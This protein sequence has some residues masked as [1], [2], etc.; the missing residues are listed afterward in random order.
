MASNLSPR[1][2]S[3]RSSFSP[4]AHLTT[5]APFRVRAAARIRPVMRDDRRRAG[6]RVPVSRCLSAAGVRFLVILCPLGSWAFL[7][8][9]LPARVAKG[10]TP[11]GLSR[12]AR[13]RCDRVGCPLCP[14]DCGAR[15][16]WHRF[17]SRRMPLHNGRVPKPRNHDP[18]P[19]LDVTRRHRGFTVVHPSGLPLACD[20]RVERR[21]LGFSPRAS[22]PAVAGG[23]CR[24]GDRHVGHLPG[25]RH[26]HQSALRST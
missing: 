7:A 1:F 8:V 2:Q 26:R 4:Q 6:H 14:G 25:L 19:R 18:P 11:T 12:F 21:S 3:R 9:G 23:A 15:H 16:G 20:P 17:S 10:R 13:M 24:G 22:H 5:S